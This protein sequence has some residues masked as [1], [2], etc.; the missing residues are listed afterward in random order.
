MGF[1]QKRT[2]EQLRFRWKNLKARATKD[3]AEAKNSQTGNNPYKRGEYT[4]IVLDIIGGEKSEALHG[5]QDVAE[6]ALAV[7]KSGAVAEADSSL[8]GGRVGVWKLIRRAPS[9]GGGGAATSSYLD[10]EAPEGVILGRPEN[11]TG[12]TTH[13][14]RYQP[15]PAQTG[16]QSP[17]PRRGPLADVSHPPTSEV[18]TPASAPVPAPRRRPPA[19]VS[20]SPTSEVFTAAAVLVP[21]P[22]VPT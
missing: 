2:T 12:P 3:H 8:L 4:D 9:H 20:R 18:L 1:G 22:E 10:A 5:I 6:D 16:M 7:A 19:D 17:V 21:A 11:F 15:P 14:H 13:A